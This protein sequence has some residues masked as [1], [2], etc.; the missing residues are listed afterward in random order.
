[1]T[2]HN[3]IDAWSLHYSPLSI[4]EAFHTLAEMLLNIPVEDREQFTPLGE[5]SVCMPLR[6]MGK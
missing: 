5:A 3:D 2:A 4:H 6:V 1:M